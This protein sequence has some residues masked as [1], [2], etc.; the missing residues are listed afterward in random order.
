[1][2]I[3]GKYSA[4]PCRSFCSPVSL[5]WKDSLLNRPMRGRS[6][7]EKLIH[8]QRCR[9]TLRARQPTTG[10]RGRNKLVTVS[11]FVPEG[12]E[13]KRCWPT[14]KKPHAPRFLRSSS[15]VYWKVSLVFR[16]NHLIATEQI[17]AIV[18]IIAALYAS[19]DCR[20]ITRLSLWESYESISGTNV[21]CK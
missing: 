16:N 10:S 4:T 13:N 8:M 18:R 17:G 21:A 15:L 11:G 20:Q 6:L 5:R 7:S 9:E 12:T 19:G 3:I 14:R 2:D 1:M